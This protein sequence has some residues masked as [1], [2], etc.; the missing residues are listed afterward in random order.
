[1]IER[2][3][4]FKDWEAR[5]LAYFSALR[6]T[7]YAWGENDCALF[8]AGFVAAIT[9]QDFAAAWRGTYNDEAGARLVMARLGCDHVEDLPNAYLP[10]LHPALAQR[11]DIVAIDGPL[12]VFLGVQWYPAAFAPGQ[13]GLEHFQVGPLRAWSV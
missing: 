1:M 6:D 13:R 8:A 4:R 10:A 5:A 9:G 2:L 3:A 7:P 11:G 12:G